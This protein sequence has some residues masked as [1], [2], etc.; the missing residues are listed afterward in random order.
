MLANILR[1]AVTA[2]IL[3]MLSRA[4]VAAWRMRDLAFTV[5]R[6]IRFRHVAAAAGLLV[7]VAGASF[8]LLTWVPPTRIGLGN[9]VGFTGNAVFVPLE[10]A[11]SHTP[12]PTAGADWPLAIIATA[13]LGLLG[14]LLPWLAFVE[15]EMFRAGLER[16]SFGEQARRALV[17]GLAHLVM[18]VPLAAGLSIGLA[19]FVY[20]RIYRHGYET[21]DG[22]GLPR[23]AARAF[24]PTRRSRTAADAARAERAS[25]RG[26]GLEGTTIT[27]IDRVPERRQAAGVLRSTVQHTTFNS[28]IVVVVWLSL[29]TS[30]LFPAAPS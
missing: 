11:V 26:Q 17:F 18:L 10:E 2:W 9:L 13:F 8:A 30:A 23:A 7:I 12:A 27:I 3:F 25:A 19:G 22:H 20:G 6:H 21:S 15:E 29:V 16:A 14:L 4:T 24:R 5:W 1:L 28:L